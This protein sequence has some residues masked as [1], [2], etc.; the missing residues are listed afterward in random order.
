MTAIMD[1]PHRGAGGAARPDGRLEPDPLPCAAGDPPATMLLP[2]GRP[3]DAFTF[4]AA[5]R[6]RVGWL[7][8]C[9]DC[10]QGWTVLVPAGDGY[11]IDLKVGCSRQCD[12]ALIHRWHQI[13]NG[14][15]PEPDERGQRYANAVVR[16]ALAE[17][18]AGQ[19]PLRRAR[20]AGS[21]ADAA[22]HDRLDLARKLTQA[23]HGRVTLEQVHAAVLE[24]AA[25]PGRLP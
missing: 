9:P 3:P 17:I 4:L 2:D 18:A 25:R 6:T 10:Q 15:V 11:A 16:S 21:Y 20:T 24:G 8:P 14:V 23:A 7:Y 13:R 19:E 12:P 1:V 5:T 22:E